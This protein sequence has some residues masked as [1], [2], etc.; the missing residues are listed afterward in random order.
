MAT[1]RD[2]VA[3]FAPGEM[4][5]I[6]TVDIFNEGVDIPEVDTLLLAPSNRER[7][8]LPSAAWARA[9]MVADSR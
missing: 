2:A 5:A 6:F 9:A 7:D 3:R 8:D 1:R 4:R